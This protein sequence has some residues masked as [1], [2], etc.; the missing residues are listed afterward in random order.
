MDSSNRKVH[1]TSSLA[2]FRRETCLK[3]QTMAEIGEQTDRDEREKETVAAKSI[4]E[5]AQ[6][7]TGLSCWV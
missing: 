5:G 2:Q 4:Q 3:Q 6:E 1:K 7:H